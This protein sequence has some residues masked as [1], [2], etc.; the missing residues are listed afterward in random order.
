MTL[1][2]FFPVEGLP[3]EPLPNTLRIVTMLLRAGASLDAVSDERTAEMELRE[4]EEVNPALRDND[5]FVQVKALIDGVRAAGSWKSYC[6][7]PH[8]SVLRLRSLITRA[9]RASAWRPQGR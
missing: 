1:L 6:R 4:A 8:K 5:I 9:A 7:L 3:R 2:A